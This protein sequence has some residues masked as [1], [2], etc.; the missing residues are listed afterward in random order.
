MFVLSVSLFEVYERI[1]NKKIKI[2]ALIAGILLPCILA[3]IRD[4]SVGSDTSG[5]AYN[6]YQTASQS[7]TL[8]EY[9][10]STFYNS[11]DRYVVDYD[12]GYTI[13]T[14]ISAHV[15][16]SF[17]SLLFLTELIIML[18]IV[19]GLIKLKKHYNISI[20]LSMLMFYFLFYNI[21]LNAMRQFMSLSFG[22][23]AICHLLTDKNYLFMFLWILIGYSFHGS[24]LL[25]L[26]L[27]ILY[28]LADIIS[29]NKIKYLS[30]EYAYLYVLLY[31][32]FALLLIVS[33]KPIAIPLVEFIGLR[34]FG[35]YLDG[36]FSISLRQLIYQV[37][38]IAILFLEFKKVLSIDSEIDI[39][40]SRF[41]LF[42]LFAFSTFCISCQLASINVNSWRIRLFFEIYN[43]VF[44]SYLYK[45]ESNKRKKYLILFMLIAYIVFF[46][47][48]TFVITGRHDTIPYLFVKK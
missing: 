42:L 2:A 44:F 47:A 34:R 27:F 35:V 38:F 17:G 40:N 23:L 8:K 29:K 9:Y 41:I 39:K 16:K 10:S 33:I 4:I 46:W 48:Y 22:F 37:V 24:G 5:Y 18:P 20:S 11:W 25:A 28:L 14:Y 21:T 3:G 13:L 43:I 30:K 36:N 32:V 7:S 19:L 26:L 15:F 12:L 1:D 45:D 31:V 6:L